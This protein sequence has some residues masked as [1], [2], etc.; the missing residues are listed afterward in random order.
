MTTVVVSVGTDHHRFDRL[1]QWVDRWAANHRDIDVLIQRGTSARPD[2]ARSV[3]MMGYDDLMAAMR[4]ATVVVVQG[5]PAGIVDARSCGHRPIVVPRRPDLGEHVD[6]HQV[7]FAR[8]TA[9]RDQIF[10]SED[11]DTLTRLLDEAMED[12]EP[13]RVTD[14]GGTPPAIAALAAAV[15][16][17]LA[18]RRR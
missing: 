18:R 3:D 16:P 14:H 5:G 15:D 6:G 11:E 7:T 10:L 9:A 2:T 8:W 12:P 13:F 17:L 4:A 1:V